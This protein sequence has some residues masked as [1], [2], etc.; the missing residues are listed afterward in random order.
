MGFF[1][2]FL[3]GSWALIS[4]VRSPLSKVT[5]IVPLV[6]GFIAFLCP[7]FRGC[8]CIVICSVSCT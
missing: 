3:E 4:R 2:G 8:E 5:T 7:T 6:I 1:F